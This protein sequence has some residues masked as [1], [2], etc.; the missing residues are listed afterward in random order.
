VPEL[1]RDKNTEEEEPVDFA[2]T[3]RR[4]GYWKP[5]NTKVKR[6]IIRRKFPAVPI[7]EK[8]PNDLTAHFSILNILWRS[9]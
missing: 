5:I 1:Q 8:D 4:T 6:K 7:R 2:S 3:V 9:F